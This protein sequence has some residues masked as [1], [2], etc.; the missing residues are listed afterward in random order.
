MKKATVLTVIRKENFK[1]LQYLIFSIKHQFFMLFVVNV[2]PNKHIIVLKK[3]MVRKNISQEFRLKNID[4][5][6]NH[7]IKN[8][9]QNNLTS[10]KYSKICTALKL[11]W[12]LTY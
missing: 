12:K 10:K 5:G 6:K 1:N 3:N 2:A 7:F 9:N 8:I 4:K 11:Y